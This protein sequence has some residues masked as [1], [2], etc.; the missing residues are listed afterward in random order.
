MASQTEL[1]TTDPVEAFRRIYYHLYS[2]SEV[3]RAEGI[4]SNIALS[5]TCHFG[6]QRTSQGQTILKTFASGQLTSEALIAALQ[7]EAPSV[8][9]PAEGFTISDDLVRRILVELESIEFGGEAHALGDAFQALIGPRLR[10][11]RGQFFT[12]RSVVR[13]MVSIADPGPDD[14]V[15]DPACGT[16]GFLLE[17][18][19]HAE[20]LHGEG[21]TLLGGEKDSELAGLARV[22]VGLTQAR[23]GSRVV[24]GNSLIIQSWE[25][26]SADIVL[27]N[28]PFGSK[29]G[30]DDP[31]VLAEYDLGFA[32]TQD[33]GGT[34]RKTP[35][36]LPS[37]DPQALFLEL[38]VRLLRPGGFLG[39]VLPEGMFGNK[40][41]AHI[42]EWLRSMGAIEA[43]LDCPR[44]TFQPGTD[45]KTNILFFRRGGTPSDVK[46]GV[47]VQCGHD[48]RGRMTLPSG[49][50]VADDFA[51]LA[52]EYGNTATE[53]W[54]Y[55]PYPSGNY[56][57]PR[58]L[59]LKER[60]RTMD[61]GAAE[62]C[63]Q[64]SLGQL[65][66][67]RLL[68]I[69]KGHE[70]G[71]EAYGTGEVPFVRT[72][73]I[74]NFEVRAD[75]TKSVSDDVYE[76]YSRLQDLR[77]GD[78]L[79]VAD[80]RYRIGAAAMLPSGNSRVVAQ[81]HLRILRSLDTDFLDPYA[82]LYALTLPAVK[83]QVRDLVFIQS[84]LGTVAP[85]LPELVIPIIGPSSSAWRSVLEFKDLLDQ[86]AALL[87][88]LS[89]M[90]TEVNL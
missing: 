54:T 23:P 39:I 67:K 30:V 76:K 70:V 22:A 12:P 43:L 64:L 45:T 49:R 81:S 21:P 44:T 77:A 9:P 60:V 75:P 46:V 71:S 79:F 18:S 15:I 73:D 4:M 41:S 65:E 25:Q 31:Q 40:N 27:T 83:E 47:A 68:K 8:V 29:I 74:S 17:A 1:P 33:K 80:G 20:M 37:Q 85:R 36:H 51:E 34:W 13:A 66:E 57:V 26:A 42:W 19:A 90:A 38:S 24:N 78:V 69:A 6:L 55:A 3:S 11:E 58:Y 7:E 16:G 84:T 35:V 53:L 14:I 72:S 88:R 28:P 48:R 2:N 10:G 5:L 62:D 32:W 59:A 52:G 89:H 82:L 61:F 86:R 56:V 50:P 63:E 87:H